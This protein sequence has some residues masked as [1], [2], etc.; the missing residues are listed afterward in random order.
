MA[1]EAATVRL[2]DRQIVDRYLEELHE[3]FAKTEPQ[4]VLTARTS[5]R[6]V[7]MVA[8]WDGSSSVGADDFFEVRCREILA[9]GISFWMR[10][11]PTAPYFIVKFAMEDETIYVKSRVTRTKADA[12]GDEWV[13]ESK[14]AGRVE[15]RFA[16]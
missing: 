10:E 8:A 1:L 16:N 11:R 12:E 13:V 6:P 2:T 3:E 7:R 5:G 4:P 15:I 9:D 14:F